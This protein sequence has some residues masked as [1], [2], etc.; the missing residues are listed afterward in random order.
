MSAHRALSLVRA[1]LR[2]YV[3]GISKPMY[4]ATANATGGRTGVAKLITSPG[5][6]P[7]ELSLVMPKALGGTGQGAN[8]EQLFALGYAA[9]FTSALGAVARTGKVKLPADVN[10]TAAVH[11]GRP[12]GNDQGFG[13]AVDLTVHAPGMDKTELDSVVAKAHELCP[14]SAATKGNIKVTVSAKN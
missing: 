5:E 3:T 9:C 13:L 11:I 2:S 10:T 14:Y 4:T 12:D 1:P 7:L 8:P 6:K